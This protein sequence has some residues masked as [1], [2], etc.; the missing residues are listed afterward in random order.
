M[1]QP[2]REEEKGNYQDDEESKTEEIGVDLIST[3]HTPI[4]K[5]FEAPEDI[6]TIYVAPGRY[7]SN[8]YYDLESLRKF[9]LNSNAPFVLVS[10]AD[11]KSD[12]FWVENGNN[13]HIE[14]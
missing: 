14:K 6:K 4:V 3:N 2:G 1:G 7:D 9:E 11:F 10:D 13:T 5:D 12:F 8:V